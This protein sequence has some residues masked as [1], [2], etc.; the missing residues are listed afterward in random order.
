MTVANVLHGAS[1]TGPLTR[2]M[3]A[4][5]IDFLSLLSDANRGRLLEGSSRVTFSA[6]TIA[7]RREGPPLA[8][9]IETGLVRTFWSVPD[10]RQA[11]MVFVHPKELVG[12]TTIT[13]DPFWVSMQVITDSRMSIL[14]VDAVRK[15]AA[16]E[17]EVSTA[18][19]SSLARRLRDAYRLIA[20]R[21]LGT[22][23]ERVAYD[24]LDRAAQSQFLGGRLEVRATQADL[25][26]SV[27]SSREV[28]S[29]T[30][31]DLRVE[32][33]VET[34]TGVIRI[35]DPARLAATVRA[36]VI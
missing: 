21:T 5:S 36:F 11:T 29:R 23:K 18:L 10:G 19:A 7:F 12:A 16:T 15:L 28:M 25:A 32:G 14:D 20:V 17:I 1:D 31:R 34:A 3:P 22:I 9:I 2:S 13:G 8:Y 30:L 24:L 6:G 35:Q 4:E 27:G 33:I 26:D